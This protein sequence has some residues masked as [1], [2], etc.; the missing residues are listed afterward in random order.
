M[1]GRIMHGFL[2]NA[3][4]TY[5]NVLWEL[6]GDVPRLEINIHTTLVGK[7]PAKPSRCSSEPEILQLR[8]MQA[9]RQSLYIG[10]QILG[11]FARLPELAPQLTERIGPAVAKTVQSHR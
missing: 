10:A 1:F 9:M 2:Q 7:L 11:L 4:E 3:E 5:G 8:R 6:I